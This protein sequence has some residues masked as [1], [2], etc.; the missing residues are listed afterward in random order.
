MTGVRAANAN[1]ARA[2]ML[3]FAAHAALR[4]AAAA[5]RAL[6]RARAFGA[7]RVA[8]EEIALM[9]V[10]YAGYPAALESMRI[11][12]D[13]WP[14]RARRSREGTAAARRARGERL[15]RRVY[16]PQF[17]RLASR[18]RDLHPDLVVWMI[19]DGYGRV[20]ARPGLSSG[21]RERVTV[22]VLAATGWERQLVSHLLGA[23][24]IGVTRL[25]V[26]EAWRIGRLVSVDRAAADRAWR[27]A[28][29]GGRAAAAVP[30]AR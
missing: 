3:R 22:A 19:E 17:E 8:A 13:A 29:P 18:V 27:A 4:D 21:E 20:L 10:L 9:L 15:C 5:R 23:A 24:R 30:R 14:G 11:V 26:A 16:G 7:R 28:F 12:S 2:D 25:R 1:A 6:L